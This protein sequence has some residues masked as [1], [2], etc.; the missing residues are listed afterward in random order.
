[1][2]ILNT[3]ESKIKNFFG[4][5]QKK[6]VTAVL[7]LGCAGMLII[8]LSEFL[9]TEPKSG[10]NENS[11]VA[12]DNSEYVKE[13]E[14]RLESK[15]SKIKGAGKTSV[16][17][18]FASSK[19]VLYA[20][21]FTEEKDDTQMGKESEIVIIEGENGEEP[22]IL[23]SEEAKIRGVLV[24]CEGG[25]NASVREKIIEALCALLDIPSNKVSVARMA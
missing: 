19:E 16:M 1:M 12:F 25:D 3:M 15:I 4:K 20:E 9:S 18:T 11:G 2:E 7:I 8:F 14:A 17:L 6:S 22:I 5:N 13:F 23:K 24:I 10:I 21:N